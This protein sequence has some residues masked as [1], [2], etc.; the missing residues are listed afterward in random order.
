MQIYVKHMQNN[1][2]YAKNMH[3]MQIYVKIYAKIC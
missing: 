1:A 3:I 2:Q